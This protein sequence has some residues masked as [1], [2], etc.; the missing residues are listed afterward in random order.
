MWRHRRAPPTP[1]YRTGHG[2]CQRPLLGPPPST[3]VWVT[4][5]RGRPPL[6][7]RGGQEGQTAHGRRNCCLFQRRSASS[8]G[9][10]KRWACK[11]LWPSGWG[12]RDPRR[13]R[14]VPHPRAHGRRQWTAPPVDCSPHG[15]SR[16]SQLPCS[17]PSSTA[18]WCV[19][20]LSTAGARPLWRWS[21]HSRCTV[22][23][24]DVRSDRSVGAH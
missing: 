6:A 8:T 10:C 12:V 4:P 16:V 24:R 17:P 15:G 18:L 19:V 11:G 20:P 1:P 3:L 14:R 7:R 2:R 13:A 9:S 22:L 5:G 21:A 23:S